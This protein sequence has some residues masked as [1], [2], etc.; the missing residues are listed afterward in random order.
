MRFGHPFEGRS[1][2]VTVRRPAVS[3]S[4]VP[5]PR[6]N[7][8]EPPEDPMGTVTVPPA[9]TSLHRRPRQVCSRASP[10]CRTRLIF[11]AEG[12]NHS[13]KPFPLFNQTNPARTNIRRYVPFR[14]KLIAGIGTSR[15][16]RFRCE[17]ENT[18]QSEKTK[19]NRNNAVGLH[20][21]WL[22]SI[23]DYGC[24]KDFD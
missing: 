3:G 22:L 12:G 8:F 6:K 4:I 16:D 21:L 15:T 11:P 20:L 18:D 13:R 9:V 23:S 17:K 24:C 10:M 14:F 5:A 2:I 1:E 7:R 19:Q